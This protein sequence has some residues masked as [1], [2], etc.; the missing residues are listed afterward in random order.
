MAEDHT[1]Q[2]PVE[3]HEDDRLLDMWLFTFFAL[4]VLIFLL[5]TAPR[6]CGQALQSN[7]PGM[8]VVA[9]PNGK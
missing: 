9:P 3:E 5:F 1:T 7:Q 8:T 2:P 6:G 4:G